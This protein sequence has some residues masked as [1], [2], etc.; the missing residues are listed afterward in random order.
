MILLIC[1]LL[2][3]TIILTGSSKQT[4]GKKKKTKFSRYCCFI[5]GAQMGKKNF[6]NL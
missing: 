3:I 1:D 6:K 2:A 5:F 4:N